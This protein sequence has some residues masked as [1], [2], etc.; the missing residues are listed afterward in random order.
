MFHFNHRAAIV[1]LS[2]VAAMAQGCSNAVI[3]ESG[4]NSFS[5]QEQASP[6]CNKD[7][8]KK[9]MLK[10]AAAKTL[11]AGYDHFTVQ[12]RAHQFEASY[13]V[14]TSQIVEIGKGKFIT[15]PS[16]ETRVG[17]FETRFMDVTMHKEGQAGTS[18]AYSARQVLGPDWRNQAGDR[19]FSCMG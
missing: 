12:E 14:D 16:S 19:L 15:I 17:T 1:V 4:A 7:G 5:L 8:T 13:E 9:A 10:T 3:T 11:Q 6:L 2:A 18:G